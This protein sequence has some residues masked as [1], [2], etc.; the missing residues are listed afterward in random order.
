MTE[1]GRRDRDRRRCDRRRRGLRACQGGASCPEPRCQRCGRARIDGPGPAPS[2]GCTIRRW[3]AAR[4]P[5]RGSTTGRAWRDYLGAPAD[6]TLAEFRA[7]R[8]SGDE[9]RRQ[10]PAPRAAHGDERHRWTVPTRNGARSRSR[11]V[12]RS[13]VWDRF[14]PAKRTD[15]PSFGEAHGRRRSQGAST[16][17]PPVTSQIQLCRLRTSRRRPGAPARGSATMRGGGDPDPRRP[18]SRACGWPA[19]RR[20]TRPSSS[21]WPAPRAGG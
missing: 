16:G 7:D 2:F 4:W 12:C 14:A 9:D 6:E 17:P 11:R 1:T 13:T 8:L 20:S 10:R 15:D 5:M 3:K 19:A 21:T 18:A